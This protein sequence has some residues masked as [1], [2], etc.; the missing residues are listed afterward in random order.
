MSG[1]KEVLGMTK[2]LL[3]R[4][5]SISLSSMVKRRKRRWI[6]QL[7]KLLRRKNR[8]LPFPISSFL[9]YFDVCHIRYALTQ[10][11]LRSKEIIQN[12]GMILRLKPR[13]RTGYNLGRSEK[14]KRYTSPRTTTF[15]KPGNLQKIIS[16]MKR[17][18]SPEV[19]FGSLHN[20]FDQRKD[21]KM[22]YPQKWVGPSLAHP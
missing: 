8:M 19:R 20:F 5:A 6:R 4:V 22:M 9:L 14:P 10:K 2:K 12:Q 18:R 1:H 7:L 11:F 15:P 16:T 3:E 21:R 17:V 13:L